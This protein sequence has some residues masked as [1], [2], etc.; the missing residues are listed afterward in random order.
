MT[1]DKYTVRSLAHAIDVL[2]ALSA[3]HAHAGL[4]VTEIAEQ[5]GLSKSS[6]FAILHTFRQAGLVTDLGSGRSRRYFLG[7]K[8]VRLGAHAR[9]RLGVPDLARPH[10]ER[11]AKEIGHAVRLGV[12]D[13]S[14]IDVVDRIDAPE[15]VRIDLRMGNLE[16]LHTTA[17]GKAVLATWPE[18][19][20]AAL[21]GSD[22]L[23]SRAPS[24]LTTTSAVLADLGNIRDRGWAID[25]EEDHPGILCLGAAVR[26]D[27]DEPTDWAISTTMLKAAV[28]TADRDRIG[29][30][31]AATA[32]LVSHHLTDGYA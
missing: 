31:L 28:S 20:V 25:D 12:L 17:L 4:G 13:G 23:P 26:T 24:S 6:A 14:R 29:E 3:D 22:P 21:L 30:A 18:D 7:M 2:D 10:L 1:D 8:L 11:L 15:G 5:V 32:G 9:A 19:D 27:D 16:L